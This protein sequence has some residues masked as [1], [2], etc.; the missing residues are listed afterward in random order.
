MYINAINVR[1]LEIFSFPRRMQQ[2][3]SMAFS[4][5]SEPQSGPCDRG[6][7]PSHLSPHNAQ[8]RIFMS[9]QPGTSHLGP[10]IKVTSASIIS[11]KLHIGR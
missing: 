11:Q 7:A 8:P 1:A 5:A 2:V 9:P 4:V 10:V 3:L 6:E